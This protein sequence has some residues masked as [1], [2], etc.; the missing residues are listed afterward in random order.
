MP[1]I[2]GAGLRRGGDAGC[3][4][5]VGRHAPPHGEEVI[6]AMGVVVEARTVVADL[7]F[8]LGRGGAGVVA[9]EGRKRGGEREEGREERRKLGEGGG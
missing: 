6:P 5:D 3:V 8:V 1:A 9:K 4:Y 2:D 7:E